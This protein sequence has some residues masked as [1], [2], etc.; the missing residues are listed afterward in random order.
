[1]KTILF[2]KIS[3]IWIIYIIGCIF[4]IYYPFGIVQVMLA[5]LLIVF[6]CFTGIIVDDY[7]I[8]K[9]EKI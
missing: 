1:M 7:K 3:V 5:L 9:K 8:E 2:L 6:V 4:A